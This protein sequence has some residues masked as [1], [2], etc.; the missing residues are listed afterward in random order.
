MEAHGGRIRAESAGTGQGTTFTFTIPVAEETAA[1]PV[2]PAPL[3]EGPEPARIL[4]I[5][6]DPQTLR[7]V[8]DALSAAG[9]A[10]LVTGEP[11]QLARIV[12]AERPRLV[13]L[14]LVLPGADGIELMQR[15]PEL[16]D[17]P[18]I[19]ISG[20]GRDETIARALE[21][22]ADDY[23]VK[24]FS[25]TELVARVRAALRKREEPEPFVLGELAIHYEERRVSVSGREVALTATEYELLRVLSL[26]TGRVVT[27]D[28][29]RRQVWAE[30]ETVDIELVRNFVKKLRAKLGDDAARPTWIFNVRAVGYRMP[31]PGDT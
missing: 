31:R 21:A 17:M 9:Y 8:R 16:S 26:N 27:Y 28:S 10:P 29:L 6:D 4:V 25:P 2:P 19:F 14:D 18:V 12:R 22:G 1:S 7:F 3:R 24:P 13:L 5:D 23:I 30:R 15:V 20:Y 11:E